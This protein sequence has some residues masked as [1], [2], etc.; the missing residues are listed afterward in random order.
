MEHKL[1][2]PIAIVLAGALIAG[3][4][5]ITR[6]GESTATTP[7]TTETKE[8][9]VA[10]V[11]DDDHILGSPDADI[12]IVEFSDTECPFCKQFHAT[13]H[14]VIDTYGRDGTVAWV[15]RHFPIEQLHQ[16]AQ[17]EAEATECAAAQGGNE[18]FWKY[19]DEIYART[20]SNDGLD[21]AQLPQIAESI[22]LD[23]AAFESCLSSGTYAAEVQK[24]Y[25]D[26]VQSGGR[27]TPH[28]VLIAQEPLSEDTI[29]LIRTASQQL[30]PRTLTLS[31]D[32]TKLVMVGALPYELL[33]LIID[34][35]VGEGA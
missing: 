30:P 22:G 20:P 32:E 12:T 21:A 18:A 1:S 6:A 23:R 9:V 8:V 13:M 4:L 33:E 7:D 27:G 34:S 5:L 35:I 24:D 17:K 16:K 15:Y 28:S 10:P 29:S 26:A 3:A 25:D 31:S 2:I 11:S 19:V 14:Q